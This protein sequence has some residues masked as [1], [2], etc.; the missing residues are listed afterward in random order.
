MDGSNNSNVAEEFMI[1][2]SLTDNEM[3]NLRALIDAG[4]RH[5]GLDAA[6]PA[7][8]INQKIIGAIERAKTKNVIAMKDA[9]G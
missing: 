5:L 2:L 4:I 8:V 1:D 6:I 3:Q 7:A 9:S